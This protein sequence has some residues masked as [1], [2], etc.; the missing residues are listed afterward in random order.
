MTG[1]FVQPPT[2]IGTAILNDPVSMRVPRRSRPI[3]LATAGALASTGTAYLVHNLLVGPTR[4]TVI[5][6]S[7]NAPPRTKR[8]TPGGGPIRH[9]NAVPFDVHLMIFGDSTATGYGC[10]SAERVPGV[11][12]PMALSRPN[13]GSGAPSSAPSGVCGQVD[14]MFVPPDA[15]VIMIGANDN[16]TQRH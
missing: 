15:A 10:A 14:A 4:L 8:R 3:A 5:P 16:G 11:I 12:A 2:K 9:G 7:F 13:N 1:S 6:K